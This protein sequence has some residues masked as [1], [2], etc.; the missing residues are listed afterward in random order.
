[1]ITLSTA[2]GLTTALPNPALSNVEQPRN[3]MSL[4]RSK[5]G[6]R[7]TYVKTRD[8]KRVLWAFQ[9]TLKKMLE[10]REFIIAYR[11]E[12]ITYR[13]FEGGVWEGYLKANPAE[14][15]VE[16]RDA[17]CV[18]AINIT[19]EFEGRKLYDN[20][21]L[22]PCGTTPPTPGSPPV[23]AGIY[24]LAATD[25]LEITEVS[26]VFKSYQKTVS[27]TLVIDD[28][29][30]AAIIH[31]PQTITD[32]VTASDSA[33]VVTEVA[34]SST[35]D[36]VAS[37]VS[38]KPR[39]TSDSVTVADSADRNSDYARSGTDSV[40]ITEG[41]IHNV[42]GTDSTTISEE[43]FADPSYY[44]GTQ[45]GQLLSTQSGDNLQVNR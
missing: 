25:G 35:V 33:V 1:M 3:T 32:S 38:D 45:D 30:A 13:D 43:V 4:L 21:V 8:R 37:Y 12:K 40:L 28:L 7:Y 39:S 22:V 34:D 10:L 36:D 17:I 18:E 15:Q 41:I 14:F 26:T 24:F 23:G 9:L 44:L 31:G 19:L 16:G 6:K 5:T 42:S 27:E 2:K 20:F 29:A 11:N